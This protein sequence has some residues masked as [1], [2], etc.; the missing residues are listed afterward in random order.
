M[1]KALKPDTEETTIEEDKIDDDIT[2]EDENTSEEVK[3][4]ERW[5]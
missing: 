3:K 4:D 1:K 5:F 2:I